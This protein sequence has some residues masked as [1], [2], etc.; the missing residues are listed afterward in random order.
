MAEQDTIRL[1]RTCDAGMQMGIGAIRHV[2][3]VVKDEEMRAALR[4]CLH[5]HEQSQKEIRELLYVWHAKGKKPDTFLQKMADMQIRLR[6]RF[7]GSDKAVAKMIIRGC[8]KGVRSLGTS[9]DRYGGACDRAKSITQEIIQ[10]EKC[11]AETIQRI[12]NFRM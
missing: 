4:Q 6:L 11:L 1:L 5:H 10:K 12:I 3:L 7:C 8:Q 9:S 2:L